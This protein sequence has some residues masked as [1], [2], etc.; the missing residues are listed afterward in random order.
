MDLNEI[1]AFLDRGIIKVKQKETTFLDIAGFPHYENVISNIYA[2]FF[3]PDQ[4]H[5]LGSLFLDSLLELV[6][7]NFVFNSPK[8]FREYPTKKG[9]RIDLVIVDQ[10]RE[11]KKVLIIENKM[12]H[13]LNNDLKDYYD[14][15]PG[16]KR[17]G[18][19]LTINPAITYHEKF[20]N[21]T[22]QALLNKVLENL[23]PLILTVPEQSVFILK[24]FSKNLNN[25]TMTHEV[26]NYFSFYQENLRSIE[27]VKKLSNEI[28]NHLWKQIDNV[29]DLLPE[30]GLTLAASGNNR[31]RYYLSGKTRSVFFTI[32]PT[33]FN[34]PNPRILIVVELNKSGIER[35]N[36]I[37]AIDF[38]EEERKYLRETIPL[39][40]TYLHYAT[41]TIDI[42]SKDFENLSTYLSTSIEKSPLKSIFEKIENHLAP[43]IPVSLN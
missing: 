5:G 22:H 43:S 19:L 7:Q 32:L 17:T 3:N 13:F 38:T 23:G 14:S 18:V 41:K 25:F 26:G 2:Y 31:L 36:E 1:K 39:R 28:R 4:K 40:K 27:A 29:P 16:M 8:V 9:G 21:V 37:N 30:L 6:G 24:E 35:L 20:A 33:V 11:D 10:D 15:F 42:A 34:T 12:F